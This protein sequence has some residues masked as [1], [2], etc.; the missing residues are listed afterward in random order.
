MTVRCENR[1]KPDPLPPSFDPERAAGHP[2]YRY[3]LEPGAQCEHER[4][5]DGAHRNGLLAW[6]DPPL[7]TTGSG[8]DQP[9]PRADGT[10]GASTTAG[11]TCWACGRQNAADTVFCRGCA[12]TQEDDPEPSLAG[13]AAA[14]EAR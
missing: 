10:P 14:R 5:H 13:S 4:G 7:F 12:S 3:L 1:C 6:H 8:N 11:W 9:P 2:S